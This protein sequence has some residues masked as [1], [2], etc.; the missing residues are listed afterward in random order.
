[1]EHGAMIQQWHQRTGAVTLAILVLF[2]GC[3]TKSEV[4]ASIPVSSAAAPDLDA[5]IIQASDTKRPM[6]VLIVESGKSD[7]DDEAQ[8][9]LDA[10]NLGS[11]SDHIV[12]VLLDRSVS[13]NRATAARFHVSETPV[14]FCLSPKGVIIS[15]DEKPLSMDLVRKRIDEAGPRAVE[16]DA[17]LALLEEAVAQN[18]TDTTA[19]LALADFLRE[20]QNMREAIPHLTVVAHSETAAT[21]LRI[22][23]WVDLA[24]AHL[25]I[26]EPEKG[27]HEA[28]ALI[29]VLGP[30][31]PEAQAG[32]KL[33]L[34]TQDA[35][36]NRT[37][38]ARQE[39]K[40]A[41]AAA[42]ESVY[43]REAGEG[44]AR[45]PKEEK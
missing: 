28:E 44:L 23:A 35:K 32:G 5:A 31:A 15:R 24:R 38:L 1:M 7:A 42:P 27:R 9:L 17:K 37:A 20:Q 2:A 30:K 8:Q 10:A 29:A 26:A 25:W 40:E 3:R 22:R 11:N 18:A 14:L 41:T 34:A 12:A 33:V 39:F 45:L 4:P 13:R 21:P 36:A 16:L 19:Q 43:A 6:L